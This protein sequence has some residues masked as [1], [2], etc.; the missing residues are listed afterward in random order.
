MRHFF[1][2][3]LLGLCSAFS[4]AEPT[5]APEDQAAEQLLAA[6]AE[7]KYLQGDFV[8]T[9]SGE[10][11]DNLGESSGR[12]R[13][14]RPGYFSWEILAP[15]QQL[16]IADPEY[17]WHY[18]RDLETVSR[19]PVGEDATLSPL[20]VLGGDE[21]A[22][23]DNYEVQAAGEGIFILT[24]RVS[25][26]GFEQAT[27]ALSGGAIQRLVIDDSIGQRVEVQFS[28]LDSNTPLTAEDFSF[29]PPDGAD[30]FYHE[31]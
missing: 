21:S 11:G 19:R 9:Q 15:D 7:L 28:N 24:P 17:I 2:S 30:L 26:A 1:L 13:L 22:L 16:V 14:L 12:F 18:D 29:T 23:R 3:L 27:I 8:Q 4:V 25:E 20:Q 5:A 31:R 10:G 6:L